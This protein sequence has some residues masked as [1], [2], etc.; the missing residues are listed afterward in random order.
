MIKNLWLI[1]DD[2]SIKGKLF[3]GNL[4]T[5]TIKTENEAYKELCYSWR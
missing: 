5:K 2:P 4:V 1:D 3:L